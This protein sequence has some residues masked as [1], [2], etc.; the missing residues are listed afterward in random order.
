MP[1]YVDSSI[2][3]SALIGETR[4]EEA[5]ELLRS[6]GDLLT[7]WLTYVEVRR[8]LLR[9]NYKERISVARSEFDEQMER[10]ELV[11]IVE[12][13][14][15]SAADIAEVTQLKSLDAVHVAVANKFNS[16][17]MNFLTFDKR[18][19]SVARQLGFSVVGA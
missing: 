10:I 9:G 7:S 19:A 13:D 6:R 5:Q 4:A 3:V 14:W 1:A 12:A 8:N 17:D 15:R 16:E 2:I 11:D 18:Q